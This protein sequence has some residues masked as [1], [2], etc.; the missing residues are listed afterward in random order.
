MT[1]NDYENALIK[2]RPALSRRAKKWVGTDAEDL[3]G[4]CYVTLLSK[5]DWE[6]VEKPASFALG[7]V[8]GIGRNWR[9]RVDRECPI[10][11]YIESLL[12]E[13]GDIVDRMVEDEEIAEKIETIMSAM[14]GAGLTRS[15]DY[16]VLARM[17][18]KEYDEIASILG[19][20][21][22]TCATYYS[23][24]LCKIRKKIEEKN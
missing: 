6:T 12:T 20:G 24:A 21:R 23:N 7:V 3:V 2:C 15:E 16:I 9:R 19:L 10:D 11:S 18:G 1:R 8:D 22:E 14:E 5:Q 13:E 17:R 4:Q